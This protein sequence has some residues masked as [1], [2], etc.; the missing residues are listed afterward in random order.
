MTRLNQLCCAATVATLGLLPM[1]VS[2]QENGPCT[3]DIAKLRREL[4]TQVG[5]GAPI[6]E[7]DYGQQKGPN[8]RAGQQAA[9]STTGSTGNPLKPGSSETDR[10]QPGGASRES[11]GSPGTVGGV[12]GPTGATGQAD[13]VASGR[14]ATS[15]EDVRRQSENRP[16]AAAAAAQGGDPKASPE[17]STEDK[18]SQA[19]MALQRAIDLNAK[20]DGG[21][22]NAVKEARG[23]MPQGQNR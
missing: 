17:R 14:V 10:T 6:S 18:A 4:S 12:S 2:A 8:D 5:L 15:P 13:G 7:P 9:A 3:D 23:L 16:T 11:G 21:C 1:T 22:A 19:K 20:G